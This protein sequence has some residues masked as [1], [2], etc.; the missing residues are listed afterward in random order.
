MICVG[1][2]IATVS[3]VSMNFLGTFWAVM[4]LVSTAFYQLQ[5]SQR[6]KNLKVNALQL[7][8]YQ[9]PQ[10]AGVVLVMTPFLDKVTGPDGLMSYEMTSS[11]FFSIAVAC[12]LAFCV[13]L[14]T[15]LVIGRTNPVS[16]Q[17][18]G[19]FKL[20]VI[21][22]SGVL[23]FGEDSN[24]IRL[25]GMVMSLCGIIGYSEVSTHTK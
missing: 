25:S 1:V 5:V 19:H 22:S 6:Q 24:V 20:V 21:L 12:V 7:L 18:L 15:F 3:D 11:A 23:V 14:S 8:H 9:A 17:V 13:N 16:Y 10:A 4:G 2:A